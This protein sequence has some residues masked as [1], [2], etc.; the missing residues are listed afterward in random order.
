MLNGIRP[1]PDGTCRWGVIS[2]T[3]SGIIEQIGQGLMIK[4]RVPP[5]G[6][7]AAGINHLHEFGRRSRTP[8]VVTR[9]RDPRRILG[10]EQIAACAGGGSS[11]NN[12]LV[13]WKTGPLVGLEHAITEGILFR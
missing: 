1:C 4:A 5:L 6:L 11:G 13:R 8:R 10:G 7:A 3:D 12:E 9:I 2:P